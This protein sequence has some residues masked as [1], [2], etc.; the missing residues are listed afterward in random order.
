M[1]GRVLNTTLLFWP[2]TCLTF[3]LNLC[4]NPCL[5]TTKIKNNENSSTL[6]RLVSTERS[7]YIIKQTCSSKLLVYLSRYDLRVDT[8]RYRF[9]IQTNFCSF[10]YL[11][12]KK[13]D[14][15]FKN[16]LAT[17]LHYSLLLKYR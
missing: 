11:I 1:F 16:G 13:K 12:W 17:F 4:E 7:Y 9:K 14:Q 10:I 5:S 2:E 15:L 8:N 3:H 6:S